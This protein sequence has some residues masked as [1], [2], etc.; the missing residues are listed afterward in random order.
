MSHPQCRVWFITGT[1]TGFGRALAEVV[2]AKGEAV[3]ATARTPSVLAELAVQYPSDRLLILRL[4]VTQPSQVADAFEKAREAFGRIDVVMN[5]AGFGH[6]G[7]FESV[8]DA[9]GRAIMDT[10]F[11]GTVSVTREALR[12]F[13]EVNPKGHGGRLLQT[14][15]VMGVVGG[16]GGAFYVASKFGKPVLRGHAQCMLYPL[17]KTDIAPLLRFAALEGLTESLAQELDPAWNIKITLIE[18]GWFHTNMKDATQWSLPHPAYT[19]PELPAA[20]LRAG[21]GSSLFPGDVGKGAAAIYK[22]AAL[23][24]PPLHFP[25]GEDAIAMMQAKSAGIK[26]VIEGYSSWSEGLQRD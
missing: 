8:D 7:E 26:Q 12:F 20:Q 24:D 9:T 16:P 23:T 21:W 17:R 22:I 3:V 11:W 15:S 2:L 13:R 18:P 5:N 10:N 19:N 1:S 25:L 14:S 6:G 4:D